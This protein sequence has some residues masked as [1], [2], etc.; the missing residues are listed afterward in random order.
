M[1]MGINQARRYRKLGK[2]YGLRVG[3]ALQGLAH[4][5]NICAFHQY[6]NALFQSLFYTIKEFTTNDKV[7]HC[8]NCLQD[9]NNL[10][11][12]TMKVKNPSPPKGNAKYVLRTAGQPL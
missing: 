5:R 9:K 1:H 3:G 8:Y 7:F 6:F 4:F 2:V 11:K 10:Y 12:P